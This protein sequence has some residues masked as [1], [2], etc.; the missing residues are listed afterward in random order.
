LTLERGERKVTLAE[1]GCELLREC[2][3]IAQ[4]LDDAR[5]GSHGKNAHRNALAAAIAALEDPAKTPAARMLA[6]MHGRH[7]DSYTAFVLEQSLAHKSTLQEKPFPADMDA[8]FAR[9]AEQS[10][11]KQ[12]DIEAADKLPFE[13]WRQ[14]YLRPEALRP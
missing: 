8:R 9:A 10:I 7:Q 1:W 11:A 3:P 6:E 12:K 5:S 4:A 2:E 14:Q 13:A